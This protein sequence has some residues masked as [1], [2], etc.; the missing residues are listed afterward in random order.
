[1]GKYHDIH[2]SSITN[3]SEFWLEEAKKV[4]WTKVPTQGVDTS[5]SPFNTWFADGEIN[6]CYN[7]VDVH[8]E[9]GRGNQNAIIYD[10][11]VT[12]DSRTLTYDQLK[13]E[14]SLFAGALEHYGVKKGDRVLIYMPMIPE[15]L[16]AV[17]ATARLGAVHS[18]VF[19]GFAAPELAVRI[20]DCNPNVIVTASC[21]I[22]PNRVIEYKPLLDEAMSLAKHKVAHCILYQRNKAPAALD[23]EVYVDWQTALSKAQPTECVSV[24][25]TDPLYILYTSGTTGQPKGVVRDTGGSVVSLKWTMSNI[26]NA[27]PGDTYWAASDIGWVV[28]HS[29]II[30]GPLFNGCTSI[31]YEGKPVG[32]PDAGAFWRV[33]SDHKVKTLFTAP[34]A[35][36]AIKKEDPDGSFLKK[37]DMSSFEILFLAGERCDPDT[38]QW[39]ETHLQVP[40]IDHWWQTETGWS[41]CANC[42]GIEHLPVVP[43]SPTVAAPGY[44]VKALDND[45]NEVARGDIGSLV[46]K[47]PLPPGTFTTLWNAPDRY[48]SA[49]FSRF[50][51][52]YETGDAGFID[53]NGYVFV[54]S[55]TDDVINV[56]GHRLSTGAMEEVLSDHPDVAECAV[57]GAADELKG[58]LPIG[59]VVLSSGVDRP[60]EEIQQELVSRVRA[61][62]GP[63][64]AFK[65]VAVVERLPKTRSGKILRGTVRSIADSTSW[66]MP[67]TIE[68]P[69]V[70][71][72]IKE[73]LQ[74]LGYAK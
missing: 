31:L 54:M 26:Y 9:A 66:K 25:S 13:E 24:K 58:Q 63:V 7:A 52:Y 27:Q 47:L 68:D 57:L 14:V 15:A 33:I 51:G 40:V 37:Y 69:A 56:A 29:Y 38:L 39:A 53:D 73:A 17:L 34:T 49:Y 64:A 44:D 11:A 23:S 55:R 1:M 2:H 46:V 5:N 36:R 60:T 28:G 30:Y 32:T 21:G 42:M 4:H 61:Q 22:E 8:V 48:K 16:V 50:P 72:E 59:L 3:P 12:E 65:S 70:L 74:Q 67:A 45:G 35:F 19:G 20:D 71:D 18:V 43:G 62:I 6:A 10:S 41:I